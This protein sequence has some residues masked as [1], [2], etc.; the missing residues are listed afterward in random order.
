[1][2]A[3][4]LACDPAL[5]IADEPTTALDVTIQAQILDLLRR[6]QREH[7]H[8]D[9]L[10]HPQSRRGRRDRRPGRGDV[11]RPDRRGRRRSTAL[12]AQPAP[13]LHA[14]P[15]R[16]RCRD[17]RRD[18]RGGARRLPPIPGT[19]PSLAYLPPGCAF[20]PRCPLRDA[21]RCAPRVPAARRHRPR[22]R[23]ALPALA[24]RPSRDRMTARRSSRS[25]TCQALPGPR[26]PARARPVVKAVDGRQLRRCRAARSSAWSA[27]S[28]SGKTTVG[29]C[30]L[31]LIEPTAGS[32]PFD[33]VDDRGARPRASMRPL[34]RRMQIVFQD[35]FASLNPRMTVAAILGEALDIH[36]LGC[37]ARQRRERVAR[38]AGL[39]G[40]PPTHATA[41]RTSSPAA[42][43][44]ASASPARSRS[45]R[46]S[47]SPTS[48]SRRWTSRSRRRSSTCC[49]TCSSGSA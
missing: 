3:M 5:L 36:G 48:R 42:S 23:S 45:S 1:M 37:A 12:F 46:S 41:T 39:V 13:S 22:P 34:R 29:R 21:E 7:R 14:G 17:V 9:P 4:A 40:S 30:V 28:G 18:T 10:H 31:R 24:E 49:A 11:R 2:I 16:L 26:R 8:G 38:A 27:R 32:G 25:T 33:G 19:V 35:P 6:L 15:A 47:S 20:A 44:S 43:A